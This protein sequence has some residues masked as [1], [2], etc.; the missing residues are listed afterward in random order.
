M[1]PPAEQPATPALDTRALFRQTLWVWFF[2][3]LATRGLYELQRIRFF[4]ENMMLF[5]GILLI[6]VPIFVLWRRKERMDFF[7]ASGPQLLRSLGWFL[8]L[9]AI[10]FPVIEAGNRWFQAEFFHRHYVGGNYQGLAKAALFHFLLVAIPEEFFYRGYMQTQF[11]RI[12]GRPFRLFGAPVGWALLFTSLLFALSHSMIVLRWWH[13]SIF[14]PSL[15][16]GWLKERTG[17]I[18][19]GALFHAL[20][21]VYSFW[22]A[23]NYR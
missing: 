22:V 7:E 10:V 6:Y 18:T 12:W 13:F 8:L 3:M 9:S 4:Q 2:T 19:A 21:N 23:L 11:N 1:N 16:F 20:C 5:T 15:A 14:F 17:A